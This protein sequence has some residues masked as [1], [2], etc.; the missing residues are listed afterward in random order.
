[1]PA[2]DAGGVVRRPTRAPPEPSQQ[3]GASNHGRSRLRLLIRPGGGIH[4]QR[5]RGAPHPACGV[6]ATLV[7]GRRT[8]RPWR[9]SSRP[10][11]R[12]AAT[13]RLVPHHCGTAKNPDLTR[14]AAALAER[15]AA[16]WCLGCT[17]AQLA[18]QGPISHWECKR[19]GHDAPD[20]DRANRVAG[21][22]W[23]NRRCP[24]PTSIH[25]PPPLPAEEGRGV[26]SGRRPA[27]HD[28]DDHGSRRRRRDPPG[29]DQVHPERL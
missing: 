28:A 20:A 6:C 24:G 26:G 9:R 22:G 8:G 21:S 3:A 4:R 13:T 23:A 10:M 12:N 5:H 17:P 11:T 16:R 7:G 2:S 29:R 25:P 14:N 27:C 15:K 18:A 1:M 19:H